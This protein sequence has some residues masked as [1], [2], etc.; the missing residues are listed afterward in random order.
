MKLKIISDGTNAGTKL[1]DEDTGEMVHGVSKL[2]FEAGVDDFIS[3][4]SVEFTNIAVEIASQAEVDLL[5]FDKGFINLVHSKT[6]EKKIKIVSTDQNG[7]TVA[8]QHIRIL[9][10]ETNQPVGAI[11]N[12]KWEATPEGSKAKVVRVRFDKKD[13]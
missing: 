4:V 10:G 7:K 3:K 6:F 9:D 8:N 1:I 13:W 12:V 11:Q 5:D 2:S